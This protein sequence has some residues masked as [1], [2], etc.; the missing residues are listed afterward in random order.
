MGVSIKNPGGGNRSGA[1]SV[2]PLYRRHSHH[3]KFGHHGQSP[4]IPHPSKN[5]VWAM[6]R[7]NI[8]RQFYFENPTFET[9]LAFDQ[10]RKETLAFF[11]GGD[12]V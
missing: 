7:L 8:Y 2:V 1:S 4:K 6:T 11:S 5:S 3:R 12:H 10:A 9:F